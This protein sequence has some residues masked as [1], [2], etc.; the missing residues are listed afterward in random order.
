VEAVC[1][2][3]ETTGRRAA[4]VQLEAIPGQIAGTARTQIDGRKTAVEY[5]D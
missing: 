4:A 5:C 1:R 2:F 3:V